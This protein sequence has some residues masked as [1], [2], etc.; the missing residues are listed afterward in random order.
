MAKDWRDVRAG[1]QLDEA[2]VARERERMQTA[3]R[4][5][6]LAE[7][8]KEQGLT[9]REVAAALHVS[10]ARVSSIERGEVRRSELSTVEAY[11]E[12][13]GGHVEVV[14]DF[15]DRRVVLS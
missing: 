9:Q 11:V 2:A 5:Y 4:A 1:L 14:A 13:L 7:I 8:R 10:Q 15:G 6:R 12:A 3:T